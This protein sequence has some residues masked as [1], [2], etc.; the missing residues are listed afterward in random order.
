MRHLG[1]HDRIKS[2]A[3]SLLLPPHNTGFMSPQKHF[4]PLL[5]SSM[6][7]CQEL[8]CFLLTI[9]TPFL[10]L[11]LGGMSAPARSALNDRF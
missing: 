5:A 7:K 6:A 3:S 2:L 10:K 9:V 4:G 1:S 8:S 11:R